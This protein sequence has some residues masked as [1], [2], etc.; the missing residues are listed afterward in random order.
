MS[1]VPA[2][3][4]AVGFVEDVKGGLC[5]GIICGVLEGSDSGGNF[6]GSQRP[7]GRHWEGSFEAGVTREEAKERP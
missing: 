4:F 1:A 2:L 5:S 3:F 6:G 7:F